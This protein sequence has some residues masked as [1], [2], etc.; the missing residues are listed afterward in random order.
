MDES[1][2]DDDAGA[3]AGQMP[4]QAAEG[5]MGKDAVTVRVVR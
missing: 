2:G 5:W 3:G 4:I 1:V